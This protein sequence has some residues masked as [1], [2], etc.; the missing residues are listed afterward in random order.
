MDNCVACCLAA[1]PSVSD[2]LRL[3]EDKCVTACGFFVREILEHLN[4]D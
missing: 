1:R 2:Q 4:V 3:N